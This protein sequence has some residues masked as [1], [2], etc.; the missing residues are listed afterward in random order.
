MKLLKFTSLLIAILFSCSESEKKSNA[1][2]SLNPFKIIIESGSNCG[3]HYQY[4]LTEKS[5]DLVYLK[6]ELSPRDT[7]MD[8]W[9]LDITETLKA[10]SN[11]N[12]DDLKDGKEKK[13]CSNTFT[14][15]KNGKTKTVNID[16][17]PQEII[18]KAISFINSIATEKYKLEPCNT[19]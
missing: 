7:F 12:L 4:I 9:E 16:N 18:C 8:G 1:P 15:T 10:I 11:F 3:T 17:H 19:K 6:D 13:D 14:M 2:L 5:Y